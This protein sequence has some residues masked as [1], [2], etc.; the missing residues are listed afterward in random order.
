MNQQTLQ[1]PLVSVITVCRNSAATIRATIASV[2][3][4]TY[5]PIQ[6]IIIDG[7]SNDGTLAEIK[8][9]SGRVDVL[10]SE[11]DRGISDAFNKGIALAKGEFIQLLN[12]DDILDDHTIEKSVALLT[13]NPQAGFVFGDVVKVDTTGN[14]EKISG[15]PNYAHTIRYTMGAIPHPSVLAR[16]RLYDVYGGFDLRWHIAMDYDWLL[17][18]HRGGEKGIYSSEI[19]VV[20]TAGGMSD[21][22]MLAAYREVRDISIEHGLLRVIAQAYYGAR[23]LKH[24]LYLLLGWR[25]EN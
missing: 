17:R 10:I 9:H 16:R 19:L 12:A 8:K 14:R 1:H 13:S 21:A 24:K 15:D 25:K 20:M 3:R 23:F 7:G 4:Q 5:S 18:V 6:Y 11:N 22:N 2:E